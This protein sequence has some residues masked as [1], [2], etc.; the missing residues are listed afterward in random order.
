MRRLLLMALS[1]ALLAMTACDDD[2]VPGPG[3]LTVTL[4]SPNEAEGAARILLVGS[5][6]GTVQAVEGEVHTRARG[7]TLSVLVLRPVAGLLRFTVQV[8]DTTRRPRA[9]VV[10]V[11]GPDNRLR[12]AL[13]GYSVEVRS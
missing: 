9:A 11:A 2:P 7:D 1:L 6:M 12:P 10:Q 4:V 8:A 3:T 13:M 5:G